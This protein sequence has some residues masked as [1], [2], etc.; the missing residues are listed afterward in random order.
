MPNNHNGGA[1]YAFL[2]GH[3]RWYLPAGNGFYMPVE[4]IDYDGNGSTGSGYLMR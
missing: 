1:N 2:D 3:C 4:G